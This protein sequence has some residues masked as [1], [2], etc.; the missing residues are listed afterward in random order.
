SV[1][2]PSPGDPR[3]ARTRSWREMR[4]EYVRLLKERTGG[5]VEVWNRRIK[6]ERLST[7]EALRTWLAERGITGYAQSLLVMEQVGYPDFFL[8]SAQELIDAQYVDRPRL[9][10]IL[11]AIVSAAREVG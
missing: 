9:R 3:V 6:K 1:P 8:A 4:A 11:D 7:P 10:P 5:G 2:D